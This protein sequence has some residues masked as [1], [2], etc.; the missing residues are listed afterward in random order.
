MECAY[1][2]VFCRKR[3]CYNSATGSALLVIGRARERQLNV[4]DGPTKQRQCFIKL[5]RQYSAGGAY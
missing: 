1:Y 5:G 2:F 4:L 3:L